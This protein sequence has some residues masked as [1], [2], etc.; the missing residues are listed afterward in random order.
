MPQAIAEAVAAGTPL[1]V[2]LIDLDH[3]KRINDSLS[4]EV[5]DQVLVALGD[6]MVTEQDGLAPDGFVARMGGEEFLV[7]LPG[8]ALMEAPRRLEA[9]RLGI[10]MHPWGPITGGLPVTASIGGVS[11]VPM[12]GDT[13]AE[14][15]AEADRRLYAAKR[16]GRDRVVC[17]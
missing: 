3:F 11:V 10:A 13:P 15:L 17:Q 16:A 2:A 7:F 5:G 6:L 1:T 4:H 8:L 9:I 12:D 14:L